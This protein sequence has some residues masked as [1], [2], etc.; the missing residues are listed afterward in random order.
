MQLSLNDFA[1]AGKNTAGSPRFSVQHCT[2]H[3]AQFSGEKMQIT[4]Y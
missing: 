3:M 1:L 4:D 2:K